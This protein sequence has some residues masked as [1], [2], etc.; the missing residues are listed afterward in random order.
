MHTL[1]A[2][3]AG[4]MPQVFFAALARAHGGAQHWHGL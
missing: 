4:K 3:I 2:M 1:G